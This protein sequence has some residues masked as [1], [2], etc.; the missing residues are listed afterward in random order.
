MVARN[1]N[2][3]IRSRVILGIFVAIFTIIVVQL[4]NLQL[5]SSKYRIQAVN[6]AILRRVVYPDRGIIYDRKGRAMLDNITNYDLAVT[7]SDA[8]KGVDTQALCS[9]LGI[10][11]AEYSK[12][13]TEAVIK[14]G[15]F[16]ASTFEPL[17]S[18][19]LYALLNESLYKFP[20][21]ALQERPVRVYPSHVGANFLGRLGE[22]SPEFLKNNS[23][24]GYQSGDYIGITGLEKAYEKVL[25][26]QRGVQRFLRDNRARIQGSYNNGDF[27][28]VAVAG[29]NLYTSI[30][31][32][33]QALGEKMFQGKIGAAVAINPKTGGIIAMI[34][35]PS[36]DPNDLT[37][38]EY[39][40]HI[41]FLATDTSR[42][43][44]N[45]AIAG[46]YPPGSTYKPMGALIAL[47]E[48]LITPAYGY[49]CHGA[50][51]GCGGIV[52]RCDEHWSGHAANLKL[53]IANSCNSYF[54]N[55]FRMTIDNPKFGSPRKGYAAWRNYMHGFGM[56]KTLGVDISGERQ[57]NIPDTTEYNRDYGNHWVSCNMVTMGIGQDRMLLTPLQSA[58]EACI[59]AN[60]GWYYTPHFVDS[61]EHETDADSIYF[62]KYRV[63]HQPLNISDNDYR[64]VQQ[65]MED[66]TEVGT[67]R[68]VTIPGVKYAAKTGTAQVP[69]L[70]N[71]EVF[72]AYAPIDNPK[73]AIA[74]YVENAGYGAT[75]AAPMGAHMMELYLNDSLTQESKD[76]AER[77]SKINL[78]PPQIYQWRKKQDSTKARKLREAAEQ[79][80]STALRI[81]QNK[82]EKTALAWAKRNSNKP[83]RDNADRQGLAI[84]S[85]DKIQVIS[86]YFKPSKTK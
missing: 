79:I 67:A 14:N 16:K 57:G 35:A 24:E 39:K 25:M 45:R 34:T 52:V 60:K 6:N 53:A 2:N 10:D 55:V 78:M 32:D 40:S 83:Q 62:T 33:V 28:T 47:D 17:L 42:P 65:G 22:V 84:L 3:Q 23:S 29:R 51:Y 5:F 49:D 8:R 69:K 26:G 56:G 44:Y 18:P 85:D 73:I 46:M 9:I 72:I 81:E 38:A 30:D 48:G 27:D 70:K 58:N 7:P 59:I 74:V 13:I 68:N 41:G 21:F 31:V 71:L 11:T 12:R 1:N 54:C 37:P 76:D 15:V 43:M 36:F 80:D 75:W 4:L 66:V 77:L 19:Q 50:Y 20:G 86:S 61:I 64:T 82:T 63:K